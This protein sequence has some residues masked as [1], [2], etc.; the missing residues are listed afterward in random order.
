MAPLCCGPVLCYYYVTTVLLCQSWGCSSAPVN[1]QF[2]E[3]YVDT[4][5]ISAMRSNVSTFE[6][7]RRLHGLRQSLKLAAGVR[8]FLLLVFIL[9]DEEVNEI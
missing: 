3:V 4:P 5:H 2:E 8:M 1:H 9:V 6:R 7:L